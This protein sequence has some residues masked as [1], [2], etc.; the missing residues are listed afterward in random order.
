[1]YLH[2]LFLSNAG[3]RR[4]IRQRRITFA[5]WN[6]R[7]KIYGLLSCKSGKRMLPKN[8]VFFADEAQALERGFRPCAKCMPEAYKKW[9]A[10][11]AQ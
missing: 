7:E 11:Q 1:M 9:R 10:A 4:L 2:H 3:V 8:R 6:G 5:G